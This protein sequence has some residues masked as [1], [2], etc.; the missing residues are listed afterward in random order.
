MRRLPRV[1]GSICTRQSAAGLPRG[2][3]EQVTTAEKR[4]VSG[5]TEMESEGE[6]LPD[7]FASKIKQQPSGLRALH[8][9]R[10]LEP[11]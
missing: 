8:L 3:G 2:G 6:R 10:R 9:R 11:T 5:P 4:E 7:G 1:P